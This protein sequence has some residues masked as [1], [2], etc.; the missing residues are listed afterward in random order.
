MDKVKKVEKKEETKRVICPNC[1]GVGMVAEDK[2]CPICKG[3]GDK[4]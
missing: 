3:T 2:V 1:S 4:E